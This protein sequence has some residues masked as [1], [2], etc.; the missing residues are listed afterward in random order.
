L[1]KSYF[2][3]YG[4]PEKVNLYHYC[5]T[6]QTSLDQYLNKEPIDKRN[7]FQRL[8]LGHNKIM[9]KVKKPVNNNSN[10]GDMM[11]RH[12]IQER[13]TSVQFKSLRF[14]VVFDRN[15]LMVSGYHHL[16]DENK[17]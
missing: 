2:I 11:L 1:K 5:I 3:K 17:R 9:Q 7:D 14:Q 12:Y 15:T 8:R 10:F 4:G 16:K 13:L 6:L